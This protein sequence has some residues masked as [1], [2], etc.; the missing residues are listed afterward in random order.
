MIRIYWGTSRLD[1]HYTQLVSTQLSYKDNS[2]IRAVFRRFILHNFLSR[3]GSILKTNTLLSLNPSPLPPF[4]N[5]S[6]EI[7]R[8]N[9]ETGGAELFFTSKYKEFLKNVR[10]G[11]FITT[12][13]GIGYLVLRT[14]QL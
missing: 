3:K 9:E 14:I 2:S 4:L 10:I 8:E 1:F 13:K 5:L 11:L 7:W 6:D 12:K